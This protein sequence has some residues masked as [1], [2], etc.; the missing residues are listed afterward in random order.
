MCDKVI[1]PI[2]I[3][4]TINILIPESPEPSAYAITRS[5]FKEAKKFNAIL[6]TKMK[7]KHNN[8]EY[9]KKRVLFSRIFL[10]LKKLKNKKIAMK[11][12][13]IRCTSMER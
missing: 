3:D 7:M 2:K 13:H 9:I 11:Y 12:K 1:P 10:F 8:S 5:K 6:K 4:N